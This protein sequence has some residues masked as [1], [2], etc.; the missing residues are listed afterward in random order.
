M[1][2]LVVC[3]LPSTRSCTCANSST[4]ELDPLS[5]L[6]KRVILSPASTQISGAVGSWPLNDS[7]RS[8]SLHRGASSCVKREARLGRNRYHLAHSEHGT[9]ERWRKHGK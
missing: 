7:L 2:C 3:R 5:M 4:R 6:L 1:A 8:R 9:G